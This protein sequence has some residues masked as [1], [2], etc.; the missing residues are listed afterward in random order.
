[1]LSGKRFCYSTDKLHDEFGL[2][3]VADI[4]NQEILTFVYN[5]FSNNLPS[6]FQNYFVTFADSHAINTRNS[7]SH[8][9]KIKRNRHMG[10][11]SVKAKDAELW[12][13]LNNDITTVPNTKQFRRKY[14][15]S[16]LT[17]N[18]TR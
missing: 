12:N 1:M 6:V 10:A 14:K 8:I 9:R 3:K 7:K 4:A 2:L 13:I 18:N 5:Y 11:N 15:E 17:Y 16:L